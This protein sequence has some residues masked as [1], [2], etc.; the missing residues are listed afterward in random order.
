L[1][2]IDMM[3]LPYLAVCYAFFYIDKVGWRQSNPSLDYADV[4]F[5]Y[6]DDS[7]LC[8]YLRNRG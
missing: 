3:I 8:S 5:R 6:S 2:K 4:R 7:E 1:W